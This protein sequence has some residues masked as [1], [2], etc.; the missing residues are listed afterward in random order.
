MEN[1]LAHLISTSALEPQPSK[2]KFSNRLT[3]GEIH[4]IQQSFAAGEPLA[5]LAIRFGVSE[6][7]IRYHTDSNYRQRV[8]QRTRSKTSSD[9]KKCPKCRTLSDKATNF[10][11]NCGECLKSDAKLSAEELESAVKSCIV[12][13]PESS[14]DSVMQSVVKAV[15]ILEKL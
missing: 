10:C 8:L 7:T 9:K 12:F 1:S 2:E 4:S 5:S 14:K 3:E 13:I 11:P 6:N 15:K